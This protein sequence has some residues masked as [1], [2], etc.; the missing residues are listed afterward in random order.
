MLSKRLCVA[1]AAV[2]FV[3]APAL[4]QEYG[5]YGYGGGGF[6]FDWDGFY[7]GVYGGGQPMS[8]PAAWNAGIFTGVNVTLDSILLGAEAQVGID[9]DDNF[10]LDALILARGGLT[11]GDMAIYA[12][13]GGGIIEG[14][15]GY[16]VGGGIEYG[17]TD[18]LSVRADALG[19][20]E[21]GTGPD[22]FR[23]TAG[24]AFH[25]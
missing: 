7:S 20:A 13:G 5:P 18:Y 6:G 1:A 17:F 4:A 19:L 24:V 23:L 9:A 3:S 8:D 25:L 12:L 15:A 21:W 10:A 11:L 14:G 22:E 2:L 16:A